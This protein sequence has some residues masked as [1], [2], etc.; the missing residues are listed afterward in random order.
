MINVTQSSPLI[1]DI[2]STTILSGSNIH[3]DTTENWNA[4]KTLVAKK[5]HLYIYSDYRTI[6]GID[7]AAMKV[8]DGNAYLIDIPFLCGNSTALDNHI[9][10]SES[11]ITQEERLF[12]NNKVTC[13]MSNGDEE[14]IVFSKKMEE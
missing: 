5:G 2:G 12:W 3:I 14:S 9:A 7:V 6:G 10:D 1:L 8:G 4:Q 11:H 13:F